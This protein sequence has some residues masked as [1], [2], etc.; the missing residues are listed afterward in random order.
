MCADYMNSSLS[1]SYDISLPSSILCHSFL[2]RRCIRNDSIT[3]FEG[4]CIWTNCDNSSC[5]RVAENKRIWNRNICIP[6]DPRVKR[7]DT[8]GLILQKHHWPSH[9]MQG[10]Q[11]ADLDKNLI[12]SYCVQWCFSD[13]NISLCGQLPSCKVSGSS[14]VGWIV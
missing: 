3:Y 9:V 6:P 5:Y 14:H 4:A 1:I 13:L 10:R 12:F 2:V 11:G 7:L 8:D